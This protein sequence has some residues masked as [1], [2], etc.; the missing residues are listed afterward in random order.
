M[1]GCSASLN[2]YTTTPPII[3]GTCHLGQ[4]VCSLGFGGQDCSKISGTPTPPLQT[5]IKKAKDKCIQVK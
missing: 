3:R 4:C 1:N 2:N 5:I